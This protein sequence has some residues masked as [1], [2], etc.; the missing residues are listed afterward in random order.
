MK[1]NT[2]NIHSGNGDIVNGDKYTTFSGLQIDSV[3]DLTR[4]ILHD[5]RHMKTSIA[6][7]TINSLRETHV[8]SNEVRYLLDILE[9]K[10]NIITSSEDKKFPQDSVISLTR[11]TTINA[12]LIDIVFSIWFL[13]VIIN[14]DSDSDSDC[15]A[16]A[17]TNFTEALQI[18]NSSP[19]LQYTNALYYQ[20]IANEQ[21]ISSIYKRDF[22]FLSEE[23][24]IGLMHGQARANN[25]EAAFEYSTKLLDSY[26]STLAKIYKAYF[27]SLKISHLTDFTHIWSASRTV[28]NDINGNVKLIKSIF[29]SDEPLQSKFLLL[30][31]NNTIYLSN[32]ED[33]AL[34]EL[35]E[36]HRD[37]IKAVI[38]Q[39]SNTPLLESISE[40]EVQ[41]EPPSLL[42]KNITDKQF[43]SLYQDI[44]T[45]KRINNKTKVAALN[46]NIQV[47]SDDEFTGLIQTIILRA[48]LIF[49]IRDV[50][51]CL[52]LKSLIALF[53]ESYKT[54]VRS[55][56]PPI[57]ADLSEKLIAIGLSDEACIFLDSLINSE[58]P[59]PTVLYLI[60]LKALI[61]SER[62]ETLHHALHL[63]PVNAWSDHQWMSY[64]AYLNESRDYPKCILAIEE[65]LKIDGRFPG[66]WI[67][68]I[69][70]H[71]KSG[72]SSEKMNEIVSR[73]PNT[74]FENPEPLTFILLEQIMRYIDFNLAE[75]ICNDI[76]IL[77]PER[78][79]SDIVKL[80][81]NTLKNKTVNINT[82]TSS[83]YCIK[84]VS[85]IIDGK[86]I[87]RIIVN[88]QVP[89]RE[90]FIDESSSFGEFLLEM[91]VGQTKTFQLNHITLKEI[92]PINIACF[93]YALSL[94][95]S[96][97][98]ESMPLK[99]IQVPE[100]HDE[101]IDRLKQELAILTPN[102]EEA[103]DEEH[104]K[105][106]L[107]F[108]P[109]FI[110]RTRNSNL[111][112]AIIYLFENEISNSNINFQ[113]DGIKEI[114]CV[115]LDI[116][117]LLYLSI[118]GYSLGLQKKNIATYITKETKYVI[119]QWFNEVEDP[120]YLRIGI[121]NGQLIRTNSNDIQKFTKDIRK[122]LKDLLSSS[123]IIEP[124][125]ID[126]PKSIFE[127]KDITDCSTYSTLR[128]AIANKTPY[129]TVDFNIKHLIPGLCT[130]FIDAE[131]FIE[132][133]N[134]ETPTKDKIKALRY[135]LHF[136]FPVAIDF[137]DLFFLAHSK[138]P[139][140]VKLCSS[141]LVKYAG[142]FQDLEHASGILFTMLNSPL[143]NASIYNTLEY[144]GKTYNPSCNTEVE[145][146][147]NACSYSIMKVQSQLT[148]EEKLCH[149]W[150]NLL[151]KTSKL[152]MAFPRYM[153][154][155]YI[156]NFNLLSSNFISG[157]FLD[158]G[159]IKKTIE[160]KL[161]KK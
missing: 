147:F 105:I 112:N 115:L 69:E 94:V 79:A 32:H 75:N 3:I 60:Y 14:S 99:S 92:K 51:K 40:H 159:E 116:F 118:T 142:K 154:K 157:H 1:S 54:K 86:E 8:L 22:I 15:Q 143:A 95:E 62:W 145:H 70:V 103:I 96:T 84:A 137:T 35:Y 49:Q 130:S 136:N 140:N 132:Q 28:Y 33:G 82:E 151:E 108:R 59:A 111:I 4:R 63:V 146:L 46:S 125:L 155:N 148:A 38:S 117:G 88:N 74:I 93:H 152:Y 67:K 133:I 123:R 144:G 138:D 6:I 25:F 27:Q 43:H 29:K 127:L 41:Q 89:H 2:H 71:I 39:C 72:S 109:Y 9:Y 19:K 11:N 134:N 20:F 101:F 55:L 53:F 120:S 77:N 13:H 102:H 65:A 119:E 83:K 160:I 50:S 42:S 23:E 114:E 73:I 5:I 30:A 52:E 104:A 106:P 44:K 78:Y 12:E 58:E 45:P 37:E 21:T 156:D 26:P 34:N 161:S 131:M 90:H 98:N 68:L 81:F 150:G 66:K 16:S 128:V 135:N 97:P 100:N 36:K 87:S 64:A 107:Q 149:L 141:L 153:L 126:T 76:F 7:Q 17:K 24:L 18:Y 56:N 91:D 121:D 31:L 129:F 122:N 47:N 124:T 48:E 10:I 110:Q 85:Y 158:F 61:S 113:H 57:I 80:H 139:D